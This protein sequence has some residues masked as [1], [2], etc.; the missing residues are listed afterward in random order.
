MIITGTGIHCVSVNNCIERFKVLIMV[1]DNTVIFQSSGTHGT[2]RYQ[3][4]RRYL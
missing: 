4:F 1:N 2:G 3:I